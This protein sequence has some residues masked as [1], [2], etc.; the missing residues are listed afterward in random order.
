MVFC[1]E[2][3]FHPSQIQPKRQEDFAP[4]SKAELL[5]GAR[6]RSDRISGKSHHWSA[7]F[8]EALEA[9]EPVFLTSDFLDSEV[10]ITFLHLKLLAPFFPT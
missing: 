10:M 2:F 4:I 7:M 3:Q 5:R 9:L 1:C 8:F 6:W